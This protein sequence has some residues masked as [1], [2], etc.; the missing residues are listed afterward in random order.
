[1]TERIWL[2]SYPHGVPAD[3]DTG[4]ADSLGEILDES[5][6]RFVN[7]PAY[8]NMG[9]T[10]SYGALH[11]DSRRLAGW[12]QQRAGIGRGDRVAIMLPNVLQYPVAVFGLL[13]IG[14]VVVNVNPL[15]TGRELREQLRDSGARAIIV[16][17][18]FA[19][20]LETVVDDTPVETVVVTRLGD[21][22]GG[23]RG[24]L[25]NAA[26][27]YVKR[28]VPPWHIR[29]A[30]RFRQ[31]LA[32]GAHA[33]PERV[34]VTQEDLAFLQ[35]TGGTT[36]R[37]KGVMLTHG[38]L[39]A[40]LQ[41]ASAWLGAAVREGE[42]VIITALP[43][44]H[45]FSLLANCLTFSRLGA[46]NVLIT[47]PRD[48]PA[49]VKTLSRTRFTAI[50]GVNTLFNALLNNEAF[51]G[52]DFSSLRLTLGGGM[53]VQRAV[54]ERWERVTGCTLV[55]AY[56]LTETSPAVCIN[57]LDQTEFTGSIGLPV[58]STE[59]SIR[60]DGGEPVAMGG[61]GELCVRGP[62]VTQGYWNRP[63]ETARAFFPGQ[64]LRT[65]DMARMDERGYV[66]IVD[67][68]KDMIIVSGFNVYP[69]EVEDVLANHPGVLEAAVIGV[70]DEA[71]GERLRAFIVGRTPALDP[72]DL[73]RYCARELT[74]YKVPRE[75]VFR[76]ELPKSNVGKILRRHLRDT[77]PGAD[78][79]KRSERR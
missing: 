39:I 73:R 57:P 25:V 7:R 75:F 43:L 69:N 55:E 15:Y 30:V 56:G 58:P 23:V 47:N 61:V 46:E 31:V 44:Y 42:E 48:I 65:G 3:I 71:S 78:E 59:V 70:P 21:M 18:N 54:A 72:D 8:T 26:V 4:I 14:A 13:S 66:Y 45:I 16:L 11:R 9:A 79:V 51:T 10:L 76:D 28:M 64:W 33:A 68:K 35:Y 2:A 50:T 24:L 53:A 60:D 52:L 37:A 19:H 1:M 40:N 34:A 63:E 49:F 74:A 67:R 22:L 20:T 5:C 77:E 27:R 12:F 32:D 38:N 41:Q 29:S 17:E 36:G 62:Q 6:D